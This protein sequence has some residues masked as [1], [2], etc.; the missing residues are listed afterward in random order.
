MTTLITRR[1]GAGTATAVAVLL[2]CLFALVASAH[3]AGTAQREP[4]H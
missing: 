3:A 4:H 1:R 2:A